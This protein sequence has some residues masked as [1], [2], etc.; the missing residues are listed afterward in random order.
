MGALFAGNVLCCS[1]Q[2]ERSWV[3]SSLVTVAVA[4]VAGSVC[5]CSLVGSGRRCQWLSSEAVIGGF[6]RKKSSVL[7]SVVNRQC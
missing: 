7:S 3:I 1:R 5:G 4:L 2:W 6:R